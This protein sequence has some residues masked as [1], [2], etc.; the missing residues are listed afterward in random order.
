MDT[1]LKQ[2][3][4]T[5]LRSGEYKQ[6]REFMR[7]GDAYCALGV[8]CAISGEIRFTPIVCDRYPGLYN[9]NCKDSDEGASS[10]VTKQISDEAYESISSMNDYG[11]TFRQIAD[12]IEA[13]I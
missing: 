7:C 8:L 5:A 12:Y 4:L 9:S 2:Q 6:G 13:N 3:W 1:E 11:Y 10:W